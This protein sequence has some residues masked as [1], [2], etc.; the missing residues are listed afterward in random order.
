MKP[1][2]ETNKEILY[3]TLTTTTLVDLLSIIDY[4]YSIRQHYEKLEQEI[5]TLEKVHEDSHTAMDEAASVGHTATIV[6]CRSTIYQHQQP[7][8]RYPLA[9]R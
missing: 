1:L 5:D 4:V 7:R 6:T 9:S 8:L 2:L 3:H